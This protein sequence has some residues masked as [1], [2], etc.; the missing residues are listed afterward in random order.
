MRTEKQTRSKYVDTHLD[1][2][3]LG[4]RLVVQYSNIRVIVGP[5]LGWEVDT[6]TVRH[7]RREHVI[8]ESL[9]EDE[10][11]SGFAQRSELCKRVC[12]ASK[13]E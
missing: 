4:L 8:V 13:R 1:K 12:I 9:K 3:E 6:D 2:S 11:A 5:L 7:G 10:F